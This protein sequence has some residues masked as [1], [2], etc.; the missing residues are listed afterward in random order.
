MRISDWSSD[1]CSSDLDRLDDDAAIEQ[2]VVEA[3]AAAR[4]V[5]AAIGRNAAR[6]AGHGRRR[7]A[8]D[9]GVRGERVIV[10]DLDLHILIARAAGEADEAARQ[11]EIGLAE[12][13][14]EHTT[15]LQSQM[16]TSYA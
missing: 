10:G 5:D 8:G 9:E 3:G 7:G 15:E 16:R 11:L 2:H 4:D 12:R 14:E 6:A 13:S 1:V